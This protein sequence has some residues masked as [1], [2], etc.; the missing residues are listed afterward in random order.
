MPYVTT[1]RVNQPGGAT[2]SLPLQAENPRI[3]RNLYRATANSDVSM[4]GH[5]KEAV[6]ALGAGSILGEEP[7]DSGGF[8]FGA[9]IEH[10]STPSYSRRELGRGLLEEGLTT[11]AVQQGYH[12]D[13]TYRSWLYEHDGSVTGG[14]IVSPILRDNADSWSQLTRVLDLTRTH[15]GDADHPNVG[16][17]IHIDTTAF[18]GEIGATKAFQNLALLASAFEDVMFRLGA[19]PHRAGKEGY[20]V[21]GNYHRRHWGNGYGGNIRSLQSPSGA[22]ELHENPTRYLNRGTWLNLG[23]VNS[24]GNGHVEFR[25]FDG[26]LDPSVWKTRI[27]IASAFV[28]AA[29]N[30]NLADAL[31][32]MEVMPVGSHR[33]ASWRRNDAGAMLPA[34]ARLS[35]E[36]WRQDTLRFRQF[37][38]IMF[39]SAA[40][41]KA[42][43]ILFAAN[44]WNYSRRT[45]ERRY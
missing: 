3:Y 21:R 44:S 17:H 19:N 42:V 10:M 29:S 24:S 37:L 36:Q 28:K 45:S 8:L 32:D 41:Q 18:S 35:G 6:D 40:Q 15:G 14:E 9:E 27:I 16:G 25:L 39:E 2:E 38:D 12:S 23:G 11:S 20:T 26:S 30:P 1:S 34:N 4:M 5:L 31:L 7:A 43:S 33:R 22:M 13:R